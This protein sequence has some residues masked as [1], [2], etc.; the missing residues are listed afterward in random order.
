[1]P[2]VNNPELKRI[3][4]EA[5]AELL[6]RPGVTGVDIGYKEVSGKP[7]NVI[8]IRVLV[9]NKRD[10][11]PDD[12]IPETIGG[13]PTD[14]IQRRFE[15]QVLTRDATDLVVQ[16]DINEYEQLKG[17]ISIGP[18]RLVNG[19]AWGG[20]VGLPVMDKIT[21]KIMLLSNY[22]VMCIDKSWSVGDVITQPSRIDQATIPN[23]VVALLQ[24]GVLGDK[25][26][27]AVA[28]V[29]RRP[30]ECGIVDIGNVSGKTNLPSLGQT[31]RKRG[32]TTGLTFG[33]VDTLDLTIIVN[34][35][36]DVG[37]VTLTSQIGVRPDTTQNSKFSDAGD[38][39]SVVVNDTA[40]V[41]GLHFAGNS[42]EGYG[43][44]NPIDAVLEA[45]NV[46]ICTARSTTPDPW[47]AEPV[48]RASVKRAP[49]KLSLY[50]PPWPPRQPQT[51]HLAPYLSFAG[52]PRGSWGACRMWED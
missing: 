12:R 42:D 8:A 48:K 47:P 16:V 7:T 41:V 31:V 20:T 1:M 15:P 39:G 22:H 50:P 5:E 43:V 32:R 49:P 17:G 51:P 2:G 19:G 13:V 38:S 6:N 52:G 35:G 27:C 23:S 9:E 34:Y 40:D 30:T 3:K 28:E 37:D 11:R 18:W 25:V 21:G 33:I 45:L 24:R 10:V 14:V 44:S 36:P 46:T 29:I 4:Q 26:D